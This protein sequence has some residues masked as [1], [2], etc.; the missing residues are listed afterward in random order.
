MVPWLF[1]PCVEVNFGI[2]PHYFRGFLAPSKWWLGMGFLNHQSHLTTPPT[3]TQVAL[4]S[5]TQPVR[6]LLVDSIS[7]NSLSI[8][9][10][11]G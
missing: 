6:L 11:T 5:G 4:D 1:N 10:V 7:D 2:Y 8:A 3:L 9:K